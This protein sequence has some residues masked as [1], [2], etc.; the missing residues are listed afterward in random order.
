MVKNRA[1]RSNR[2]D[3]YKI[4]LQFS[5]NYNRNNLGNNNLLRLFR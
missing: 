1:A 3:S 5:N 2:N 4:K